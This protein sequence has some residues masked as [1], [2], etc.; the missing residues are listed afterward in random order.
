MRHQ[1][2]L[3]RT[4]NCINCSRTMDFLKY[5]CGYPD[6]AVEA[7]RIHRVAYPRLEG[8]VVQCIC[9]HYMR[10]VKS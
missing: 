4:V 5:V 6:D 9:G 3:P 7:T 1:E 10:Y 2:K 8:Y